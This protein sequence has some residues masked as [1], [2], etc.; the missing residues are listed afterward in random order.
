M[1]N[2]VKKILQTLFGFDNYLFLF[3]LYII[4]T[5][6]WNKREKDFLCFLNM[7]DDEGIVLDIGANIGVMTKYLSRKF[8]KSKIYSFEPI[9]HNIT[10]LKRIIKYFKLQNV[11]V[12]EFALGDENG[13]IEMIMPIDRKVKLQGLSHIVHKDIEEFNEGEK[14]HT[15]IKRLDDFESLK[16]ES[17]PIKG[18]KLDVENFEYYVLKGGID[19]IKKHKPII[20]TELWDNKNRQNCF[21]LLKSFNYS[22]KILENGELNDF[23]DQKTQNFFFLPAPK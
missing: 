1:K 10:A 22:I 7:L 17:L 2:I 14:F 16:K 4:Y 18:I 23:V 19:I 15:E 6:R 11:K 20:Y 13:Q 21:E 9:P 8:P 12:C 5:L 3:A